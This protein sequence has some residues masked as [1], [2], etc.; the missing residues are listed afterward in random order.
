MT[1]VSMLEHRAA[2]QPEK[3][4]VEVGGQ[5]RTYGELAETMRR[6]ASGLRS[7]GVDRG[8]RVAVI[9]P[10]R[11][12]TVGLF[13][14]CGLLGAVYVPLNTYLKGEFLQYQL[15]DCG[16]ETLV[17]DEHGAAAVLPLL[18][19]L[20]ALRRI[21]IV[22]GDRGDGIGPP[23]VAGKGIEL[24]PYYDIHTA[25][26]TG[27]SFSRADADDLCALL[28]TSGTTGMPKGCM[29]THGYFVH[30]GEAFAE[31]L[32]GGLTPADVMFSTMPLFHITGLASGILAPLHAG[33]R[34]VIEPSFSAS[35]FFRRIAETGSTVTMGVGA[36]AQALLASPASPADR[37]H[38][39]RLGAFAPLS[40][41]AQEQFAA[42][43]GTEVRTLGYGQT[44]CFPVAIDVTPDETAGPTL[45][46]S[47]VGRPAPWLEVCVVADDD[48]KVGSD[49]VGEIVVRPRLPH[50]MFRGYWQKPEETLLTFRNLW[51]HTGDLG[52]MDEA[53]L[54]TFLDRKKDA[55]RRRGENISSFEVE[56][57]I[58]RHPAVA[59]VAVHA[60]PAPL[61]EDDVKAWLVLVPGGRLA[62][63][64][65]F[66]YFTLHLPYFAIPRYVQIVEALPRNHTG[67]LLKNELRDRS[68]AGDGVW[69]FDAL[70]L[71]VDAGHRRT[72]QAV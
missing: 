34:S 47:G 18:S 69:D 44:E 17:V 25:D 72:S 9:L 1:V 39:L 15:N 6:L 40:V 4:F 24:R 45:E 61:G 35:A 30:S 26:N 31:H 3:P 58:A 54:L 48:T 29:A 2:Q 28:Y 23:D 43:F 11:I 67:K 37:A 59:D 5:R 46:T 66:E 71:V 10:N 68:V 27:S 42:R 50:T 8:D 16:A 62:P 7:A 19:G 64:E 21:F 60:V 12:E 53:G 22:D 13:L 32:I 51:H 33:I 41:K 57:A 14:G 65:L 63:D 70:G 49:I 56:I 20:P 38:E 55:I 52:S 36:M